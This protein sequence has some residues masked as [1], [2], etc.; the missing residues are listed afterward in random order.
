MTR[1]NDVVYD[2]AS[3]TATVGS[4]LVW[5]DVYSALEP[6]GVNVVGGRVTVSIYYRVALVVNPKIFSECWRCGF[7]SWRR[8]GCLSAGATGID[9][10]DVTGL[11][12]KSNQYGLTV[13]TITQFEVVL[14]NGT[15]TNV[16][17]ASD[18]ELFFAL[19]VNLPI[20]IMILAQLWLQGGFNNYGI[21]TRF[22]LKTFPQTDVWVCE[23]ALSRLR[24][25]ELDPGRAD[26]I[27]DRSS[28]RCY[29]RDQELCC[30][31]Y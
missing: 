11:S 8:Y 16:T 2:A 19:K 5:D 1:F 14:P 7:H 15:A 13:D 24:G 10:D 27:H 18:S 28:R 29:Q 12:W 9:R 4:G 20:I 26:H 30:Y 25:A 3:S 23:V 17:E 22:T 6:F 21:V 31:K